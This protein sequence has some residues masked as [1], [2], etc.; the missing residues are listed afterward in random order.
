[1]S[2]SSTPST[3][4]ALQLAVNGHVAELVLARPDAR[5]AMGADFWRELPLAT[6]AIRRDPAV[7]AV[8]VRAEGPHFSAGIDLKFARGLFTLG[9]ADDGRARDRITARIHGLQAAFLGLERLHVPV[10]AA[11]HGA[12]IGAG[13]ELACAADIRLC[14]EDAQFELKEVQ[15]AIVADLGGLQRLDRQLPQGVCRELAY[16]GRPFTAT[17]AQR[18]NF[19]NG[20]YPDSDSLLSAARELAASIAANSPLTVKYVKESLVRRHSV[21]DEEELR[22]AATLQ[23]AYGFGQ[24]MGKAAA[25]IMGGTAPEYAPLDLAADLSK[26]R[27]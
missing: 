3:F 10:I 27:D 17:E 14:S 21:E 12:C 13:L 20:V 5:N 25:A 24:D 6:D 16:T 11:V 23:V 1:M 7:R 15:L 18:W 22:R 8:I 2:E 26:E 19:V 9:D 4:K